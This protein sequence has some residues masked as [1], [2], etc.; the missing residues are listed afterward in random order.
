M[1]FPLGPRADRITESGCEELELGYRAASKSAKPSLADLSLGGMDACVSPCRSLGG[2]EYSQLI[3]R[4]TSVHRTLEGWTRLFLGTHLLPP[5][6]FL[7]ITV[8]LLASG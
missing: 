1:C 5:R 3:K 7:F 4:Q 6:T 2:K 8:M